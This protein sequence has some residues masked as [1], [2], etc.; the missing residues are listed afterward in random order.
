MPW[1]GLSFLGSDNDDDFASGVPFS[2]VPWRR[3]REI[4]KPAKDVTVEARARSRTTRSEAEWPHEGFA[5]PR[6]QL[7]APVLEALGIAEV[8]HN[9]RGSRMRAI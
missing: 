1:V 9:A 4:P 2:D 7:R 3:I 5:G 6:R 8:E